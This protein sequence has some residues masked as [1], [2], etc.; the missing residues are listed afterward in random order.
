MKPSL[1][2]AAV[3]VAIAWPSFLASSAEPEWPQNLY[4][5]GITVSASVGE[6]TPGKDLQKREL[7]RCDI[8]LWATADGYV[9]VSQVLKST[10]YARLDAACLRAVSGKK[11]I[12]AH[13]KS[14]PIDG[15]AI[16]P[17]TF[18]AMMANEPRAPDH[19]TPSPSLA[20]DQPL[21][22]KVSDY[23][24]GALE[25][26]EHGDSWVHVVVSDSGGV[27]DVSITESSGSSDLDQGAIAAIGSARFNPAY[28]DHKPVKSSAEVMVSWVLLEPSPAAQH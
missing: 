15:W 11:M 8:L 2:R 16:L 5:T 14:G 22:V 3:L 4:L 21:H 23:P 19:L 1:T 18:E 17:V 27:L 24:R 9:R 6:P 25:R 13:D 10:G 12:P 7:G 20:L 26:H 28:R